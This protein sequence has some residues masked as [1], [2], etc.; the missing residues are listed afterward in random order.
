MNQLRPMEGSVARDTASGPG[1][2][3]RSTRPGWRLALASIIAFWLI[4]FCIASMKAVIT[5]MPSQDAMLVR[6]AV[7]TMAAIGLTYLLYLLLRRCE[8]ASTSRLLTIAFM[9]AVPLALA[10]ATVNYIAF[11][12]FPIDGHAELLTEAGAKDLRPLPMIIL[13]SMDWY[14]FIA[15]WAVLWIAISYAA[16]VRDAERRA[17][18]FAQAA[19]DSELRALRYQVNPHF[20]FNTLNSLSAL[21]MNGRTDE[22]ERMILNLS[23]FFRESLTRDA[24]EDIP[25]AEEI[26]L[27]QLYLDIEAVRFPSRLVVQ[28]DV[29]PTLE[30]AMV[31]ALILQPLVENAIK[32]GVS[33]SRRPVAVRISAEAIGNRLD[34][35]VQDDA[36]PAVPTAG[37]AGCGV[38]LG[39][40]RA[41][42][43]ARFG[44]G[45]S[46]SA[47]PAA[48]GGW[49]VHLSM[50]LI[51]ASVA[52]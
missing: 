24:R 22:A 25:L 51:R 13:A 45:A 48:S 27:Q 31:P 18:A 9:A 39:N 12:L 46:L 3:G 21:V 37:T 23:T 40:V 10:Y 34:L 17:A 50:P 30:D 15:T 47:G 52:N 42:L 19:V 20:L 6:R 2:I 7:V 35:L 36:D 41:R 26:R 8:S 1:S 44:D 16:K 5:E 28:I 33:R 29:P 32:Y 4:Y 11:Y 38:G 49:A 43:S 14:F